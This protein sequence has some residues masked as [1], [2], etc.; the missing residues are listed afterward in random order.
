MFIDGAKREKERQKAKKKSFRP[1]RIREKSYKIR[2]KKK[3]SGGTE[4]ESTN[5]MGGPQAQM[6]G[7]G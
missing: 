5:D 6:G 1:L 7:R 2:Q 3:F 4:G